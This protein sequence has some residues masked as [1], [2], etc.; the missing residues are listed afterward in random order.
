ML[1]ERTHA[2][3]GGLEGPESIGGLFSNI[4]ENLRAIRD[5][6]SFRWQPPNRQKTYCAVFKSTHIGLNRYWLPGSSDV[7]FETWLFVG[8]VCN[9]D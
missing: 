6:L 7:A 9:G 8:C 3:E 1:D 2:S 5:P 4:E